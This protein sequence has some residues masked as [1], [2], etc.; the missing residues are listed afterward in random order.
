MGHSQLGQIL[1]KRGLLTDADR[2]TITRTC[3]STPGAFAKGVLALGLM[4][5]NDLADLIAAEA[6]VPRADLN[7]ADT[8]SP[9]AFT[10]CTAALVESMEFIPIEVDKHY[11]KAAVV[12]P[13]DKSTVQRLEFF[14]GR[15]LKP[16]VATL[17]QVRTYLEQKIEN[18]E[19]HPTGLEEFLKNHDAKAGATSGKI[20]I[21][22]KINAATSGAPASIDNTKSEDDVDAVAAYAAD[23]AGETAKTATADDWQQLERLSKQDHHEPLAETISDLPA[24]DGDDMQIL[25]DTAPVVQPEASEP[26]ADISA[27]A[28]T[29][30][31]LAIDDI[32]LTEIAADPIETLTKADG[33]D[34]DLLDDDIPDIPVAD[35]VEEKVSAA[36]AAPAF[37][38]Q[39]PVAETKANIAALNRALWKLETSTSTPKSAEIIAKAAAES[40]SAGVILQVSNKIT[41]LCAWTKPAGAK[42]TSRTTGLEKLSVPAL[43]PTLQNLNIGVTKPV[44]SDV[45]ILE[46][47][48]AQ[49]TIGALVVET[50]PQQRII[51]VAVDTDDAFSVSAFNETLTLMLRRL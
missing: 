18:F 22:D 44:I 4:D 42:F 24:I 8:A 13:L 35:L 51:L 16:V 36:E 9:E 49:Q 43:L 28:E 30:E 40:L 32:E 20:S 21:A 37:D 6:H 41:P 12:D 47:F 39:L 14:T 10:E 17:S 26:S 34:G 31:E 38:A 19:L 48:F 23:A 11:L 5:E 7:L 25:D 27:T 3:G 45:N 2:Q 46:D 15:R 1:I 50:K 33:N 29:T